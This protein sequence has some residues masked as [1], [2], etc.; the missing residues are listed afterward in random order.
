MSPARSHLS[1]EQQQ[2][3]ELNARRDLDELVEILVGAASNIRDDSKL[4]GRDRALACG[5]G[6]ILLATFDRLSKVLLDEPDAGV[7][8]DLLIDFHDLIEA[9][10]ILASGLKAPVAHSLRT[11]AFRAG[12]AAKDDQRRA[13]VAKVAEPIVQKWPRRTAWWI[14]GEIEKPVDTELKKHRLGRMG[15]DAIVDHL[16]V[17]W[18]HLR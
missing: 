11:A 6:A 14:A 4:I 13:I 15:R 2:Q 12:K 7:R 5:R 8:A 16:K 17:L 18:H 1:E 3:R 9:A 10:A